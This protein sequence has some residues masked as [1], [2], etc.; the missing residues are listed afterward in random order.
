M[1]VLIMG[2]NGGIGSA[3]VRQM[4]SSGYHVISTFNSALKD[5]LYQHE[6]LEWVKLDLTNIPLTIQFLNELTR[7]D[8]AVHC[9]GIAHSSLL[10]KQDTQLIMNQIYV[11]FAS[12]ILLTEKLVPKMVEN[13]FGRII[14]FGSIVGRDGSIGL[15]TYAACKSA[16]H[17]LVKSVTRELPNLKQRHNVDADFTINMISPG[18]SETPMT[19]NLPEKIK[20]LIVSRTANNRFVQPGE[21]AALVAFLLSDASQS[22]NGANLEINGGSTL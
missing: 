9:A 5:E 16:L 19:Q 8:I 22:I 12:S 15:S 6:N 17:G 1:K 10:G 7:V 13:G 20:E 2:G 14:L 21:I 11:N 18:Y 3:I 4:L